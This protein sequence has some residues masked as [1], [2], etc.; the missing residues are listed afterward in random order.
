MPLHLDPESL[1]PHREGLGQPRPALPRTLG[2]LLADTVERPLV[3][4][5][6]C[7]GSSVMAE[8]AAGSGLDWLLIDAEHSP[9]SL[10]QMQM[11]LQAIAAYPITPAIRVPSADPVTIKQVLDLGVQ[12]IV[13]PM[14]S[15][16]DQARAAVAAARYAPAG[17]RGVGSALARSG[18]WGRV[19]GY[20]ENANDYVSVTVQIETAEGVSNAEEIMQVDGVD[21]VFVG[22]SDLAASMGMI[23]RQTHPDVVA[24]VMSV[25]DRGRALGIPV[26]VNA[27]DPQAAQDYIAGGVRFI[28]VGADVTLV[29]RGSEALA[30]KWVPEVGVSESSAY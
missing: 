17:V 11:Q 8:I 14:V 16:A 30:Q 12:N 2:S 1:Q 10:A 26:G 20:L 5:W 21:A 19:P 15:D 9:L 24:A 7:S 23:G 4:M 22:P 29:A 27:F 3:G 18:R 28:L 6:L 13:V 25:V